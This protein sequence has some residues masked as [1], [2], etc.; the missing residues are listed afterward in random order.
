MDDQ[1][2][3]DIHIPS[4]C[5]ADRTGLLNC[6]VISLK[7]KRHHVIGQLR[8][9][10]LVLLLQ[11]SRTEWADQ[12]LCLN[13]WLLGHLAKWKDD[14]LGVRYG[15]T[16]ERVLFAVVPRVLIEVEYVPA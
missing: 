8:L 11:S 5:Q 12:T 10:K 13:N 7:V 4:V 1:V 14:R 16:D 9:R 3:K 15:V 2:L 6:T